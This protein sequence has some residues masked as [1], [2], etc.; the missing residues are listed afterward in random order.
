VYLHK[1]GF[2]IVS[3]GREEVFSYPNA[4]ENAIILSFDMP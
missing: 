3:I 4:R 1:A 2:R